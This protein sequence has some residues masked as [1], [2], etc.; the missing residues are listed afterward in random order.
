MTSKSGQRST[1]P[2]VIASHVEGD[3]FPE[4]GSGAV[5][6]LAVG[7]VTSNVTNNVIA[8]GGSWF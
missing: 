4:Q 1:G 5:V 3:R 2:L 7:C 6:G 8:D